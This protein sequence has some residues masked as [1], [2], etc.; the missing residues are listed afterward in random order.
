MIM[1]IIKRLCI[2]MN[3]ILRGD[4]CCF[5]CFFVW[6]EKFLMWLLVLF[7]KVLIEIVYVGVVEKVDG[8][9]EICMGGWEVVWL[10]VEFFDGELRWMVWKFDVEGGFVKFNIGIGMVE[11]IVKCIWIGW[12][13]GSNCIWGVRLE[14]NNDCDIVWLLWF[15]LCFW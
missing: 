11:G 4:W 8:M 7:F 12:I 5:S 3:F 13:Y 2:I 6:K 14:Y 9:Y 1:Y 10:R 15:W